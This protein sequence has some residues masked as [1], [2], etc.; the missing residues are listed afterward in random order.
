MCIVLRKMWIVCWG[1]CGLCVEED[2][3][4]TEEDVDCTE[5]DVDCVQGKMWIVC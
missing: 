5:E 1:R 3:D 4:C 2:V